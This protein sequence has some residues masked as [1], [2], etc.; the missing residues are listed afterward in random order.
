ML[1]SLRGWWSRDHE[2]PGP[3]ALLIEFLV[4]ILGVFAAQQMSDWAEKRSE[5]RRVEGLYRELVH[6]FGQYRTIAHTYEV[7]LPCLEERVDLIFRQANQG[8]PID[9]Q[10]LKH[11][12]LTLMGPDDVSHEDFQLLRNR[13]GNETVDRIGSM[14]FNLATSLKSGLELERR[15]FE[16]QRLDSQHGA[17]DE[18]DRQSARQTAVEIKAHLYALAKS[19]RLILK[20]ADLLGIE[21]PSDAK[22]T[23]V[24]DCAQM[25]RTGRGFVDL[26]PDPPAGAGAAN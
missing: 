16:F 2:T 22:L 10:L 23:P 11:A 26:D 4:V 25:W 8:R 17:I 14:Q 7:A 9:P 12:R 6:S 24:A 20:L 5:V 21:R 18:A 1:A 19:T 15:W 3:G 13:F